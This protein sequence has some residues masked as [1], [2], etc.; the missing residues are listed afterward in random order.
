MNNTQCEN[1]GNK[2][3]KAF[4][5]SMGEERHVF[6]SF[7]CAINKLAPHCNHCDTRIIGHGVEEGNHIYCCVSCARH[8]G[9]TSLKDRSMQG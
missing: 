1:C 9:E 7:E 8:A 5:V 3:D 2:Y 4:T 6:D